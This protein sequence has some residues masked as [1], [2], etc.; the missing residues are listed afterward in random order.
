MLSDEERLKRTRASK[1]AYMRKRRAQDPDYERNAQ[2]RF[3]YGITLKERD[4]MLEAQG[5]LCAICDTP[6]P[7]EY[8][9]WCVDHCH[10][11]GAVRG[12]LCRH[13][14]LLLGYAR[15]NTTTLA[16]AIT[17]LGN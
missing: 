4:A 17:Y 12:I 6:D 1:A 8:N 15:D 5:G 10:A 7:G 13:C 3:K 16:R 14:N 9:G 2:F 11:S